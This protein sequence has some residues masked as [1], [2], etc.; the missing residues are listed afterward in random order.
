M[1]L[2]ERMG[3]LIVLSGATQLSLPGECTVGQGAL[4]GGWRLPLVMLRP[5]CQAVA[6]SQQ[7]DTVVHQISLERFLA[8]ESRPPS[9]LLPALGGSHVIV[10][11]H[12]GLNDL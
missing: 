7:A 3:G 9:L 10:F 5:L 12:F 4:P 8:V 6:R 1:L 2:E 11:Q